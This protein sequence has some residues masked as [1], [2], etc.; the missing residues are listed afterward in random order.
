[1]LLVESQPFADRSVTSLKAASVR[2]A[3]GA[4]T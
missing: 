3:Q 1:M 2:F 4:L